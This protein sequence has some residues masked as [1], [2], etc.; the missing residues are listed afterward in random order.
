MR[1]AAATSTTTDSATCATSIVRASRSRHAIS[2]RALLEAADRRHVGSAQ[3]GRKTEE[4]G[5]HERAAA[6]AK[7]SRRA[8]RPSSKPFDSSSRPSAGS[9]PDASKVAPA[10]PTPAASRPMIVLL[11]HQLPDDVSACRAE[12]EPQ[13]YFALARSAARKQE[14]GQVRIR[15]QDDDHDDPGHDRDRLDERGSLFGHAAR[16]ILNVDAEPVAVA[17]LGVERVPFM[18]SSMA[19]WR[20]DALASADSRAMMMTHQERGSV[21]RG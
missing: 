20:E 11:D 14:T 3:C 13:R 2:G 18:A 12:R 6:A 9:S 10:M 15:D 21:C 1:S 7:R 5:G 4:Q 17:L 19:G 16:A 8:F